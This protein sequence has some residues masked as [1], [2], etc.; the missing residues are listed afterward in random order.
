MTCSVLRQPLMSPFETPTNAVSARESA[1]RPSFSHIC[2][3]GLIRCTSAG[4][5]N[6]ITRAFCRNFDS[7]VAYKSLQIHMIGLSSGRVPF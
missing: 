2:L 4:R 6:L 7:D 5:L 3:S 1:R